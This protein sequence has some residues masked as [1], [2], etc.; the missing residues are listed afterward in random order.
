MYKRTYFNKDAL[1][2]NKSEYNFG[3]LPIID[4]FYGGGGNSPNYSR[5]LFQFD[6]EA[7]KLQN[8]R[9]ELGD[10]TLVKHYLNFKHA[11]FTETSNACMP[12]NFTVCLMKVNENWI[13][14]CG[15][16]ENCDASCTTFAQL[17][18]SVEKGPANW[19]YAQNGVL[20]EGE[21]VFDSM[22][23]EPE[24]LLCQDVFCNN[25]NLKIDV[26]TIVN[27]LIVSND[28][29][30]GFLL[31]FH[32]DLERELSQVENH[33]VFFGRETSTFFEP[34]LETE[35]VNAIYDDR[36]KFYLD[37]TNR[38][39]LYPT[40]DGEKINLDISPTVEIYNHLNQLQD[41]L[42]AACQDFG[43]YYI[44]YEIES[45]AIERCYAWT[46]KWTQIV[47]NGRPIPDQTFKFNLLPAE[48]YY[49]FSYNT[50]VPETNYKLGFRGIKR[51]AIIR[52]GDV[53]KIFIDV[54]SPSNPHNTIAVDNMFYKLYLREGHYDELVIIDWFP[55]NRGVCENWFILDTSWLIPQSYLIDF[56]IINKETIKTYPEQI[57]FNIIDKPIFF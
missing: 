6:V 17:G 52:R 54:K 24:Y 57:K 27:D 20:W 40:L 21:G 47:Y 22:S 32:Y 30:Y 36:A 31:C 37:K 38:L 9:C 18:C 29:N 8:S 28:P 23:F 56:K 7:L 55:V 48:S 46:D 33:V 43:V 10:L 51:D 53:H 2:V 42:I 11:G 3:S 39:Y 15:N 25:G 44:E 26:T 13:E 41:T 19:Y 34:Y 1:I 49:N 45:A 12:T 14:G 5:Y 16:S 50:P 35:Y 4:L